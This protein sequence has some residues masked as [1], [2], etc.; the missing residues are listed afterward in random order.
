VSSS[1]V[2]ADGDSA[3][4]LHLRGAS[5]RSAGDSTAG[6]ASKQDGGPSNK[7]LPG[8]VVGSRIL[9]CRDSTDSC[10]SWE[11]AGECQR[12]PKYMIE[13]CKV[14]DLISLF[15]C[16]R[17]SMPQLCRYPLGG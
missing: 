9:G 4:D 1:V 6:E 17:L 3:V 11:A 12:N 16:I 10:K 8:V 15:R 14:S 13:A 7:S 5:A 2:D